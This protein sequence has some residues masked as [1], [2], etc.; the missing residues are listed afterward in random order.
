M[1][2]S[3]KPTSHVAPSGLVDAG[4]QVASL[5]V[6]FRNHKHNIIVVLTTASTPS[7]IPLNNSLEPQRPRPGAKPSGGW[8]GRSQVRT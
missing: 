6:E 8:V 3:S 4:R 1:A 2:V 7:L 5:Q